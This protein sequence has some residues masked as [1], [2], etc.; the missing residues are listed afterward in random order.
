MGKKTFYITTPI[1][2]MSNKLHIGN[3][4]CTVVTD[5]MARY[6]K[7]R[8]Y[9]VKFLT[10]T[11]DHGQKVERMAQKAGKTPQDF[12]DGLAELSKNL[13]DVMNCE[14]DIFMRTTQ[15]FHIK[16]CQ[17]LFRT[18]YEKGDIYK[19][20]YEGLYCIECETFF[21]PANVPDK[22][23]LDCNRGLDTVREESYF[24]RQSK[25]ADALLR[26]IEQ[27]PDFIRPEFR[28]NEMV[29]FLKSGLE[30]IA[31]TR[32]TI[33]WGIP[34]DFDPK[35]VIYVWFDALPNYA[36]ALGLFG[37]DDTEYKKYW[38]ADVH[39]VGKD[40]LRFHTIL[41]PA[42]L[43]ALGEPLPKSIYGTGFL[44]SDGAKMSKSKGNVIDPIELTQKYGVDAVR[45]FLMR[46]IALG[47][48]GNCTELALVNRINA[49]LANDLGNLL[50]RT[51]GMIDKY[52]AGEV[53]ETQSRTSFD[54]SLTET[55]KSSAAKAAEAMDQL[56]FTEALTEIWAMIRR[57]NKY[58][59]ET[60]PW[61]L[62]RNNEQGALARVLYMLAETLRHASIL[63]SPVMPQ[64]SAEIFRQLGIY[65][66]KLKSWDSLEFGKLPAKVNI[67]KGGTLFPRIDVKAALGGAEKENEPVPSLPQ[68]TIDD[69][70]KLDLRVGIIKECE[71]ASDKLLKSQ[72]DIGGQTR[73]ILSGIAE[74]YKP[75]DMVGK[76]VVVVTNLKPIKLR[77][78]MSEGMILASGEGTGGSPV[79]LVTVEGDPP[80]GTGVR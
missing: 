54:D 69:F 80:A 77:G 9:D 24:F 36:T 58:V 29:S 4:Y 59:D 56:D 72:I 68:I 7:L 13:W 74:W 79:R 51:V 73:Q 17:K 38:P 66:D 47:Q 63:V 35:H 65:N 76:R 64:A 5:S 27:N 19:A 52:F 28:K 57:A 70:A 26:H 2:Y 8:G 71:K 55:C 41:W 20:E 61:V 45:Y 43:L 42:M 23:C 75:E 11:D 12:V 1:Y 67:E 31:V 34:V 39:M 46:E 3:A 62:H 49:D 15:P 25:Y 44:L 22:L 16:A 21:R 6:K 33:K 53:P 48:D 32:T 14:Y 30:D 40:I 18:L 37:E 78:F 10:G 50:S 60:E